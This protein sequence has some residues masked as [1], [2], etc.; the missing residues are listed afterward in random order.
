M[1][2]EAARNARRRWGRGL[3]PPPEAFGSDNGDPGKG[4]LVRT[5]RRRALG[6]ARTAS[7]RQRHAA[8]QGGEG[9]ASES[10]AKAK[11]VLLRGRTPRQGAEAR[12]IRRTPN[13]YADGA[14]RTLCSVTACQSQAR[15]SQAKDDDAIG[16]AGARCAVRRPGM[17]G[18][19]EAEVRA[20]NFAGGR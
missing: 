16:S 7:G 1:K 13:R 3:F 17:A 9:G 2:E 12:P 18:P 8:A 10:P 19:T 4:G 15:G 20:I 6:I 5:G 14:A 11:A